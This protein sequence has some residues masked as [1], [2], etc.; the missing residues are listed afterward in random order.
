MED[1]LLFVQKKYNKIC[2]SIEHEL[3]SETDSNNFRN[4]N[5]KYVENN[6]KINES[7][8]NSLKNTEEI[9]KKT[10]PFSKTEAKEKPIPIDEEYI[11]PTKTFEI[12]QRNKVKSMYENQNSNEF[13]HKFKQVF[14]KIFS[15]KA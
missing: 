10:L 2:H 12:M 3:Y 1:K 13:L 7:S 14:L 5:E 4:S 9:V 8:K 11:T 6:L 15:S